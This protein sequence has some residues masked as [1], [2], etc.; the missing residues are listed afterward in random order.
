VPDRL[1]V[2]TPWFPTPEEPGHGSFVAASV[3]AVAAQRGEPIPVVHL[4]S[5]PDDDGRTVS[6]ERLEH[7]HG[8][9]IRIDVPA[10]PL[11]ARLLTARAMHDAL[12]AHL[13]DE[14]RDATVVHVHTGMPTGIGVVDLLRA[15]QRIVL[16]E[17]ASYLQRVFIDPPSK[18]AYGEALRRCAFVLSVS[19]ALGRNISGAF[20]FLG[21][22]VVTVP[23]PVPT[24]SIPRRTTQ[25]ERLDDWLVVSSLTTRKNVDRILAVFAR[26]HSERPDARLTIVGEGPERETLTTWARERGLDGAVTFL[27]NVPHEQ[28]LSTY[29][30]HSLFIHLSAYETFGVVLAEAVA[31][32]LC[33]VSASGPAQREVLREAHVL[34]MAAL[35]NLDDDDDSAIVEAVRSLERPGREHDA[36]LAAEHIDRRFSPVRVGEAL[37]ATYRGERPPKAAAIP[38]RIA[39]LADPYSRKAPQM[40][41]TVHTGVSIGASVVL[42]TR[43]G[44]KW[45]GL[46]P[47]LPLVG[48]GGSLRW[49]Y[50]GTRV[51]IRAGRLPLEAVGRIPGVGRRARRA[52]S[53]YD[54]AA[55]KVRRVIEAI[56]NHV[57]VPYLRGRSVLRHLDSWAEGLDLI[58]A[59]G[60]QW[61]PVA[62]RLCKL[63]AKT[64]VRSS[65]SSRHLKSHVAASLRRPLDAHPDD[66][67][68]GLLDG[69]SAAV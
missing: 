49:A 48:L 54:A 37:Q 33:V 41:R 26:W 44:A 42:V 46:P 57:F 34:D 58:V 30:E 2:I 13:P 67:T 39:V 47:E 10:A 52:L 8:P 63:N 59:D 38:F 7:P 15:D 21:N 14:V 12:A 25:P 27:G 68:A 69:R 28:V 62:W 50:K 6:V 56:L 32:G 29:A 3:A 18:E 4:R 5:V 65:V 31:A 36:S 61:T 66:Q 60:P 43:R 51:A 19:D 55:A 40:L 16:T 20:P 24:A 45:R 17:H 35:V 23:N 9:L 22:R 64:D 53:A 11:Q 1:V